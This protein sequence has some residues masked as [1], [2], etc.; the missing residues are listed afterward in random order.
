MIFGED[1]SPL[2]LRLRSIA[3][4][5]QSEPEVKFDCAAVVIG[6]LLL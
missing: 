4:D 2:W 1:C 5:E 3:K 6:W